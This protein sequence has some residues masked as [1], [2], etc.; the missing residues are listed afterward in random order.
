MEILWIKY[1][2]WIDVY[3]LSLIFPRSDLDFL[4][5]TIESGQVS[6]SLDKGSIL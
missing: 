2:L 4:T 1:I 6:N 3:A 5:A